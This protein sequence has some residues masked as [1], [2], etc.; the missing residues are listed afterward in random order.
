MVAGALA[1]SAGY[2]M[3]LGGE[4]GAEMAGGVVLSL[5]V[6]AVLTFA[7]RVIRIRR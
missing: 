6:P 3:V 5:G 7:D 2:I 1:L 4:G